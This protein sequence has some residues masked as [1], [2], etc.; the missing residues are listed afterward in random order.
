MEVW[1]LEDEVLNPSLAATMDRFNQ[2]SEVPVDL[3]EFENDPY[4]QRLQMSMGS[5][6]APDVF[7]N[8][9]GGH[10]AQY[11]DAGQVV[12]MTEYLD[13]HP[14]F[15]DS[16]VPS[17]LEVAELDGRNYGVPMRGVQPVVLFYNAD[18]FADA[19]AEPPETL[20][21]MMELV[22]VFKDRGVTPITLPG[23]QSW[24]LLMWVSYL[25]DRI[26][27]ADVY[28]EISANEE[29]AWSH[30]A[31]VEAMEVIQEMVDRGAFGDDYQT[32]NYDTEDPDDSASARLAQG[33]A[34]MFL[35][36]A[37]EIQGQAADHTEFVESGGLGWT[38]FPAVENGEGDPEALVGPPNNFF[39]VN[40]ESLH[41]DV[42]VD[43]MRQSLASD[44]YVQDLVDNGAVPAVLG[45]EDQLAET[46]HAE[47]LT[48]VYELVQDA[49]TFTPAWDQ[50][51]DPTAA[52]T[53]LTSFQ[54]IFD[55]DMPPEEFPVVMGETQWD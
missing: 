50:D 45:V 39:S 10:L 30:P 47:Y 51:L 35:M 23:A 46:E 41:G 48:W 12:D 44:E 20:G 27:G 34:A 14:E 37:W 13:Q 1:V 29:D 32:L 18:V 15:R 55:G 11:V 8:W 43:W 7:F 4:K 31:V 42:A 5:A 36:G 24:T 3:V 19:G 52:E 9:G 40:N 38:S 16:F 28:A 22:D 21:E 2:Q 49:P 53:M 33:D 17:V 26:G 6:N 25:V 54:L